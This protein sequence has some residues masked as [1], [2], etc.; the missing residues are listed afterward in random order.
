MGIRKLDN[1]YLSQSV[2]LLNPREPSL[3]YE[4]EL[5]ETGIS[6][7]RTGGGGAVLVLNQA[8]SL[9]GIFTERDIVKLVDEKASFLKK[10]VAEFM[11]K[12]PTSI[13]MTTPLAF[14][15]NLMTQGGFRHIPI[16][17]DDMI[18][19]GIL[20]SKDILDEFVRSFVAGL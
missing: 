11:T 5:I 7:I 6:R 13:Q 10:P 15:L 14:A 18:P 9:C 20:S 4:Q 2:G 17:D 3:M 8:G 19:I 1:S 16:V 12:D